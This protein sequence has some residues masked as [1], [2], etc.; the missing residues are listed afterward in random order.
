[1][2]FRLDFEDKKAIFKHIRS[3]RDVAFCITKHLREMDR[4]NE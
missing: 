3:Q 4:Q 2:P 1:M